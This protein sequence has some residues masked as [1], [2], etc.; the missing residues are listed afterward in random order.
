M[1]SNKQTT[2]VEQSFELLIKC[3]MQSK[4]RLF[5]VGSELGL[6]SMQAMVLLLLEEPRPMNSLT[7][8]L[9]CDAS[10]VTGLVDGLEQKK[11]A[12]RFPNQTDRRIKM[13]RLS[14]GGK[15]LRAKMLKLISHSDD[16]MLSQLDYTELETL[17]NLLQKITTTK[18]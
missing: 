13:V 1:S 7:K 5:M 18:A 16:S 15:S 11:L 14:A 3:V 9:S 2:L 17:I 10:N 4:H 8:V 6:T 12:T